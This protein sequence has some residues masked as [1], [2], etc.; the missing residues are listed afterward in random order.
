MCWWKSPI[1]WGNM[2]GGP[3][4][5]VTSLV[6]MLETQ[7]KMPPLFQSM[8]QFYDHEW[9]IKKPSPLQLAIG[10]IVV[11][12]SPS[13]VWLLATPRTPGLPFPHHLLEFAQVHVHCIGSSH[14]ILWH[15]LL[16]LPSIFLSIR[17]FFNELSVHH[18]MTKILE[19]QHQFRVDL[20]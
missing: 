12:H 1:F 2:M 18:Q 19:L 5:S 7:H 4:L 3:L 10:F 15:P 17:D 20:P 11:A 8:W 14:L 6:L 13:C 9:Q 16:L